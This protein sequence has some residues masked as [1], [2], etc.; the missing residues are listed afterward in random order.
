MLIVMGPHGPNTQWA[1]QNMAGRW[2]VSKSWTVRPHTTFLWHADWI[3]YW[4]L[5][6]HWWYLL[7]GGAKA[8][9]CNQLVTF[10]SDGEDFSPL[11]QLKK[12]SFP[13]VTKRHAPKN[14]AAMLPQPLPEPSDVVPTLAPSFHLV[15]CQ[16]W[17]DWDART[18][19]VQPPNSDVLP[20]STFSALECAGNFQT[21]WWWSTATSFLAVMK[22]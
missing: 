21:S 5:L 11:H 3:K 2:L 6:C 1:I 9:K 4:G 8:I 13:T 22:A 17:F 15:T 7:L 16:A 18:L 12:Q 10:N 14:D 19:H 20:V